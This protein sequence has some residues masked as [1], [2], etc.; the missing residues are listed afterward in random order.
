MMKR[1]KLNRADFPLD[2][3]VSLPDEQEI[4]T[5]RGMGYVISAVMAG[6]GFLVLFDGPGRWLALAVGVAML[7]CFTFLEREER[8]Q[9]LMLRG[10]Q[11]SFRTK[12]KKTISFSWSEVTAFRRIWTRWGPELRLYCGARVIKV[13]SNLPG[14]KRLNELV[15][16]R[17]IP[18]HF[19]GWATPEHFRVTLFLRVE[20]D[21][22]ICWSPL[23]SRRCPLSEVRIRQPLFRQ[24]LY[25]A[26]GN[27]FAPLPLDLYG[28]GTLNLDRLQWVLEQHGVFVPLQ[29]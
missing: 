11:V 21:D 16:Q 24:K 17:N 26:A 29:P 6:V 15:H 14:S 1:Q 2:A 4:K 10:D 23:G 13:P 3:Q 12:E 27:Y 7:L 25:D 9:Y 22:L 5:G 20:G 28:F 19:S 8:A 18:P